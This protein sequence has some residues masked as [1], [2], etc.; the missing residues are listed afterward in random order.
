MA[1]HRKFSAAVHLADRK[2]V[3]DTQNIIA[4]HLVQT[5]SKPLFS[6]CEAG[7]VVNPSLTKLAFASADVFIQN[8]KKS[9]KLSCFRCL[10]PFV[11]YTSFIPRNQTLRLG[12]TKFCFLHFSL[13]LNFSKLV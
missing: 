5:P 12:E 8:R 3:H 4:E 13:T 6:V 2:F 9:H 1:L 11:T 7:H 10:G